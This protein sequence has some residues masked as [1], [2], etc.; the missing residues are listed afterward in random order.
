M[1]L[2]KTF[3]DNKKYCVLLQKISEH[4]CVIIQQKKINAI[5]EAHQLIIIWIT[6]RV[7]ALVKTSENLQ[8][9]IDQKPG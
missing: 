2:L 3:S 9:A 5:V 1:N 8:V 4:Y 7:S 6:E